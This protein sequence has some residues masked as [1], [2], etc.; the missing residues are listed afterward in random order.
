M[1]VTSGIYDDVELDEGPEAA[2][3]SSYCMRTSKVKI[4]W[5]LCWKAKEAG[6]QVRT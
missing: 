3:H 5:G 2:Q 6:K 4:H 1:I